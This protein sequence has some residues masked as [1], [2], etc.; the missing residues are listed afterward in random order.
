[1]IGSSGEIIAAA[2]EYVAS[3]LR[4]EVQPR[5]G[6]TPFARTGNWLVVTLALVFVLF[7]A[8]VGRRRKTA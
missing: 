1:V 3:V 5:I 7:G 2:P 4:A 6:L 8:H